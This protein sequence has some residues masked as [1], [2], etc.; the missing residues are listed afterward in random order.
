M[1]EKP[2]TRPGDLKKNV[3]EGSISNFGEVHIG[4]TYLPETKVLPKELTAKIPTFT[5]ENFIG[6][7]TDLEDLRKRLFENK[8]VVIVNGMG[9]IGK[10]T[11]AHVYIAKYWDE[12]KHIAYISQNSKD[13]AVDLI[14]TV[15]LLDE[16]KINPQI[17]P[18]ENC[19]LLLNELKKIPDQPNLLVIDN[20]EES[21]LQWLDYLPKWHLLVTSR[22]E[23]PQFN[24]KKLDFLTEDEAVELFISHY[25][26]GDLLLDEIKG[27]VNE[28]DLHTLVIEILAKTAHTQRATIDKLK[29]AIKDDIEARIDIPHKSEKIGRITS[30]LCSI[31]SLSSL[32]E[33]EIWLLKQFACLPPEFHDYALLI[34]LIQPEKSE[35]TN[36][37]EGIFAQTLDNLYKSGWLLTDSSG[38]SYKMHRIISE[39]V[40]RAGIA[41]SD[42]EVLINSVS[43][44]L[45]GDE[46][47]DNPVDKFIWIPFGESLLEIFSENEESALIGLEN[48]LAMGL[49][50]LGNYQGAKELL[51]K[52]VKSDENNFGFDHSSTVSSYSNLAEVLR[53]LGDYQGAKEL[54]EKAVKSDENNFGFDHPSTAI[55]YSNL[56]AVL[57]D[58][59]DY[60]SAKELSEKV[61]ESDENNFGI[62]HP[63]TARS[64]SNLATVLQDLGDYHGA[65]ELLEKAVKS[66][67][68][69]FGFDHP[70]TASHYSNL[71]TVLQ[72]LG[73]YH[74]ARELVEKAVKSDENNFG[75]DHPSTA[76]CYSILATVLQD[77]GDYQGA[78]ELLEKAVKSDENNFGID[79]PST[80][81]S[82]SNLATVLQDLGDYQG[83][84][85][86]LE[87]AV[88]SDEKNFGFDHPSTVSRYSNLAM[89]LR[90]LG[91][92]HGAK[93][94]LHKAVKSDENNFGLDHPSTAISYNNYASVL[95][96]LKEYKKALIFSEKAVQIFKKTLPPNHPNIQNSIDIYNGIQQKINEEHEDGTN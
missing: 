32:N 89:V 15:W 61:V 56:A 28:V 91:D 75:F 27:L 48:N 14:Q 78:K 47:R 70:L 54:L 96:C 30:Y 17:K 72:D 19:I 71:A 58:L 3:V 69:N 4:D 46:I 39:V 67:E 82:Y 52:V 37:E 43:D 55:S 11:L 42:V 79:H 1:N 66:D 9:G 38:N 29:N 24:I 57:R 83:A 26:R 74:G 41:V 62:D 22:E 77:L 13:L 23:I 86:L 93:E 94:L 60:Q 87:K 51:E 92:Y 10:S 25:K 5:P 85:E 84:K 21:L 64:Y 81:R 59:G 12:Y 40:K 31:F 45:R 73:D 20:A 18:H 16:F 7:K 50:H 35:I 76:C 80:A 63:S 88:K 49:R 95:Y 34:K 2:N 53:N 65:K 36:K 90:N 8:Q 6:R 44:L 33:A 68:N